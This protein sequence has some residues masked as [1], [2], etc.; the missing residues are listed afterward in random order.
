MTDN[1]KEITLILLEDADTVISH[2]RNGVPEPKIIRS[3]FGPILRRWIHEGDY[4]TIQKE[5]KSKNINFKYY[6][7]SF[8]SKKSAPIW[9]GNLRFND[10]CISMSAGG[11]SFNQGM[12]GISRKASIFFKQPVCKF[13]EKTYTRKDI[14]RFHANELGGAHFE[15]NKQTKDLREHLGFEVDFDSGNIQTL[16]GADIIKA[17]QDI[18]RRSQVYD[19]ADIV[20]QD[21]ALVFAQ[22][23][24]DNKSHIQALICD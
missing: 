11:K 10:I 13:F 24:L 9:V 22:G 7:S 12:K 3:F 4:H 20:L 23:I 2:F 19:M 15:K 6:D 21:T 17:K 18:A 16:L 8:D 14:V 5:L 1:I